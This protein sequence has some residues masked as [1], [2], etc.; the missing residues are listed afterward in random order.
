LYQ[1]AGHRIESLTLQ[2]SFVAVGSVGAAAYPLPLVARQKHLAIGTRLNT[3][4][5]L[6]SVVIA[7]FYG[8]A[9]GARIGALAYAGVKEALSSVRGVGAGRKIRRMQVLVFSY[10]F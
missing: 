9:C 3:V 10:C 2:L 8:V 4:D 7:Y 5:A 1:V 6:L